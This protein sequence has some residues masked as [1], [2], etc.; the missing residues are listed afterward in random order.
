MAEKEIKVAI[1]R[2]TGS[3]EN[4]DRIRKEYG[5]LTALFPHVRFKVFMMKND[6]SEEES[7]TSYGLPYRAVHLDSR[8]KY[9]SAS[10]ILNKSWEFYRRI[11]EDIKDYDYVWNSGDEPTP[12]LLFIRGKKIIWD[13]R[14][15][16]MFLLGSTP[17]KLILKYLFDRCCLLLHANQYRIDYLKQLGLIKNPYKHVPIRNFPEFGTVD[18]EY[19]ARYHEVKEW[20]GGRMCVYLQGLSNE[21]RAAI[22]SISAVLNTP[23]LCAIVLGGFYDKA[24]D[25]LNKKYGEDA[26]RERICFAGNFRVLKVPQYMRLCQL[27]LVFYKNTTPN[28]YYCEANRLY[29]AIEEGLPVVVGSNP[30]MKAVVED[31]GVGISIDTDGSN[32]AMITKGIA[33]LLADYDNY[34]RNIENLKDEIKW[35]SQKP[36]IKKTFETLF[37]KL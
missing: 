20:I 34:K 4:D 3:L 25:V 26:V 35:D 11:K 36:L 18:P 24:M 6:N 32:T 23:G 8:D 14:E 27:S 33:D 21:S 17:K 9:P 15:L 28:N 1:I 37:T 7:V 31:L 12:T 30:S 2:K 19:D 22:E 16:P 13:L 5:S 10:H 29:Q